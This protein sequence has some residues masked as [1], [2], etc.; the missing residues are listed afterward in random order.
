MRRYV[1][2]RI[3][4]FSYF[5]YFSSAFASSAMKL[6]LFLARVWEGTWTEQEMLDYARKEIENTVN[7]A[8]FVFEGILRDG[9]DCG[10]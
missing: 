6:N 4:C 9:I 8:M 1:V 3:S 10:G 2:F 5:S 7:D